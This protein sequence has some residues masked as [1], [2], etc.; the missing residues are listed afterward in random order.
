[1]KGQKARAGSKLR[2]E[3]RDIIKKL[4]KKRGY[5]FNSIATKPTPVNVAAID[6]AFDNGAT[7]SP[8]TL[9]EQKV[10]KKQGGKMPAVKILGTGD[11]ATKVTVTNCTVSDS[12]KEKIEKAGGSISQ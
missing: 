7:V 11:I 2:P 4:P 8:E 10:I 1:M 6:A 5:K 9:V 12:A 3:M